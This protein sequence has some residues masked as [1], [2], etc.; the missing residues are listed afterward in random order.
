LRR[1]VAL[2]GNRDL[3]ITDSLTRAAY[4]L[5]SDA[6]RIF[7]ADHGVTRVVV[8]RN[9]GDASTN[10]HVIALLSAAGYPV[11]FNGPESAVFAIPSSSLLR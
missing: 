2:H 7:L 5:P 9:V 3:P 1:V 11:L 10:S 8:H 4:G 6:Q